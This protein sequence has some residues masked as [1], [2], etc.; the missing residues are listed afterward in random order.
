MRRLSSFRAAESD[1]LGGPSDIGRFT[2]PSRLTASAV[3]LILSGAVLT[4]CRP[5][6]PSY[7]DWLEAGGGYYAGYAPLFEGAFINECRLRGADHPRACRIESGRIG[8]SG[9]GAFGHSPSSGRMSG[10]TS[11]SPG[12]LGGDRMGGHAGTNVGGH[13]AH[14]GAAGGGHG[15]HGG[16]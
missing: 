13:T 15:G 6:P 7:Y 2:C 8:S 4:A 10:M 5:V 12:R 3:A 11:R 1:Q 16:W 9:F 14:G